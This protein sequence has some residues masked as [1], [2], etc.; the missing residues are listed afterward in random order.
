MSH[1]R[2]P[3]SLET[4]RTVQEFDYREPGKLILIFPSFRIIPTCIWFW[5]LFWEAKCS[6][7]YDVLDDSGNWKYFFLK[8]EVQVPSPILS[9][10]ELISAFFSLHGL[11]ACRLCYSAKQKKKHGRVFCFNPLSATVEIVV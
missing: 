7:I 1:I 3:L 6:L 9:N 5:S 10:L 2:Y 11:L 8:G 4:K